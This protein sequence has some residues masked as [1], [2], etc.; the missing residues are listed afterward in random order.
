MLE[1][2]D[3]EINLLVQETVRPANLEVEPSSQRSSGRGGGSRHTINKRK[4]RPSE[5]DVAPSG[6]RV[7]RK[8]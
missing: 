4:R 6:S 7:K 8:K 2:K 1:R 3:S 5:G